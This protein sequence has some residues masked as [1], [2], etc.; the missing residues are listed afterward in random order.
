MK[1]QHYDLY[2]ASMQF[3][4]HK[5]TIEFIDLKGFAHNEKNW[6]EKVKKVKT[7]S[8]YLISR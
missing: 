2:R 1:G 7:I 6:G 5:F 8:L 3:K 4:T